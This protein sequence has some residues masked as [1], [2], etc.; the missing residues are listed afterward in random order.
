MSWIDRRRYAELLRPDRRRP[1]AARRHRPLDRGRGGPLRRRRRGGLRRRQDDPRVDA[2][3][4]GD[5]RRRRARPRDHQRRRARPLGR[6]Q[7]RRR[8][9]R[10]AHRRARQGRQPGHHGRRP[11]GAARSA[12]RPRSSPA[13]A[14][15]SPRARST[16]TCTSSA[17]RS[18]TRRS[19]PG[20]TTLIGGGTGP[21]EGTQATTCTPRRGRSRG[22]SARW[23]TTPVNVLLLGKGNTVSAERAGRAGARGRRRLQAARGLGL[24]ARGDRRLPA[25]R[26]ARAA[27]RSRSTPTRSTRPATWSRR[28]AAIAG[29]SIHAYHTEGAGGGHAPDIIAIAS[30]PNVLPSSTNPT[31]PH[32]VNTVA[33][34]LDMLIVCHHLN[35]RVPEDLAFAESRIRGVD[36]RRRGRPARPRRDLDDRL[37]L[38]GDGPRRARRSSAP[39]RPRT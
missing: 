1:R 15:S 3:G 29:R 23:T 35:P 33:E 34:H 9:P 39:G 18:S 19:P 14:G 36:D 7:V 2:P 16:A 10:R 11:P 32:T 22:C 4:H 17:R 5:P 27:S 26:R 31:R 13:R 38:A 28:S 30:H 20:V 8:H 24:D 25:R 12:R 37:R 21:A 6:R